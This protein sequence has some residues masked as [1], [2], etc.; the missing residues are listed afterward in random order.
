M[1]LIG[2][3]RR[4]GK[5][6]TGHEL[7]KKAMIAGEL[8]LLLIAVDTAVATVKELEK[9]AKEKHIKV[10]FFSTKEKLGNITGYTASAAVGINDSG[11]AS[12]LKQIMP[13]GRNSLP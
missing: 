13:E 2:L 6:V 9:L 11:F 10:I 12:R 4:A 7:L 8:D 1:G 3:A 5:V